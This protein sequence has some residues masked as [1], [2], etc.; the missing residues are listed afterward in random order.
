MSPTEANRLMRDHDDVIQENTFLSDVPD[1][2]NII[3]HKDT[4]V[5]QSSEPYEELPSS[6]GG[7]DFPDGG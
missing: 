7:V 1:A 2:E 6:T 3:V 4:F 5:S